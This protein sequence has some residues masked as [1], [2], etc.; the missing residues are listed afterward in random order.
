LDPCGVAAFLDS[1]ARIV[2][3]NPPQQTVHGS[4][5]LYFLNTKP[6][7]QICF[8]VICFGVEYIGLFS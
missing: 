6:V 3:Q 1:L 4:G 7:K 2:S 5:R 8:S